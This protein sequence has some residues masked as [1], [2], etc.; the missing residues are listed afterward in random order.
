MI[1]RKALISDIPHILSVAERS[2][3]TTEFKEYVHGEITQ[4]MEEKPIYKLEIFCIANNSEVVSYAGL[5]ESMYGTDIYELRMGATLPNFRR[6]G[7]LRSLTEFRIKYL[8]EKLK[9]MPGILHVS[10]KYPD[11]YRDLG[12]YTIGINSI[13]NNVMYKTFNQ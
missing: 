5:A 1:I 8:E 10:T 6:F 11:M 12:F 9:G 2:F 3:G 7:Y 4:L 13:D